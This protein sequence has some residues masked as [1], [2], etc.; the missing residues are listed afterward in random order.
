MANM[1]AVQCTILKWSVQKMAFF[2][3][4]YALFGVLTVFGTGN[5]TQVNTIVSSIHSALHNLHII[6]GTV[7]ERAN[8]IFGIF[9][10]AFVAMVL[11]WRNPA[12]RSGFEKLVPFMAALY[13]ILAIGVVI[14]HI[15]RVP[16]VFAMIFKSAFTPQ[17]AHRR[18]HHRKHVFKHEK[19]R[20]P[21][22]FFP[23]K[24]ALVPV[25][26]PMLSRYEQCCPSGHVR[27]FEV[28]MD[29]IVICTL[30]G[31]VILL[32]APNIVYGQAAGAEL[33]IP[34]LLQPMGGW[35][36]IFTAV[37]MSLLRI[38]HNHRLGLIRFPLYRIF[39]RR[40]A[41]PSLPC[42][43]FLCIDHR[44]NNQPLVCFGI[45]QIPSTV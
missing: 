10:A 29:T 7:D 11:A 9:I 3:D 24:P 5:A 44:C 38:Q 31:L 6:D 21:R 18:H 39:R 20:L 36:S 2:S 34:A 43:L 40:K 27:Y 26:S 4:S 45:L 28:F 17:A 41:R 15:S 14:L 42:S 25:P 1:L 22:Y 23:M 37:A 30:T 35:V 16:A 33:T 19:R 13:V 12:D 32:G 8:L